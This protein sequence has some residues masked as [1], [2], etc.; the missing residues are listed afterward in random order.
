MPRVSRK[1]PDKPHKVTKWVPS[2]FLTDPMGC[3]T[4]ATDEGVAGCIRQVY[5]GVGSW[6]P[7][8]DD[9]DFLGPHVSLYMHIL[10]CQAP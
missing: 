4:D 8:G 1:C 6:Q 3:P 7:W 9:L 5:H 2:T 10:I